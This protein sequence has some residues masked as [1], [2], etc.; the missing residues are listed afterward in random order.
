M[1]MEYSTQVALQKSRRRAFLLGKRSVMVPDTRDKAV[2]MA[3]RA[4]SF[5][6]LR[7]RHAL[8]VESTLNDAE[9]T[10]H[11]VS[12]NLGAA[13]VAAMHMPLLQRALV[14]EQFFKAGRELMATYAS[15]EPMTRH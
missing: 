12:M 1:I 6:A 15:D 13:V 8:V 7:D 11:V 10:L 2:A 5:L 3:R 4:F 14:A 9:E